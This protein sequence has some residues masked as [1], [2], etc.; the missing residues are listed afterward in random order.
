MRAGREVFTYVYLVYNGWGGALYVL[1]QTSPDWHQAVVMLH[2]STKRKGIQLL[3]LGGD[4]T[5]NSKTFSG[6]DK[7]MGGGLKDAEVQMYL[8]PFCGWE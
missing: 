4:S 5:N 3:E 2:C 7:Y 1:I 8:R 6:I